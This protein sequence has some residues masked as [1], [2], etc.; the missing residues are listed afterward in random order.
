MSVL[1]QQQK[2]Q[3]SEHLASAEWEETDYVFTKP[4]GGHYHP[5]YLSRLL[6]TYSAELG[7]PR[8]TAHGLKN[9]SATCW[10]TVCR[11]RW[12]QNDWATPTLLCLAT[13]TAR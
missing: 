3:A 4:T 2:P 6:G 12:R 7:L 1:R 13:S 5:Q 10:P 9:T 8:L 11:L